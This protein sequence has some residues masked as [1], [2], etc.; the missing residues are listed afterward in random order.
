MGKT[1]TKQSWRPNTT[2]SGESV[3]FERA[4]A[5]ERW[6]LENLVAMWNARVPSGAPVTYWAIP[7]NPMNLVQTRTRS[8]AWVMGSTMVVM[9]DGV[10]G[11][12]ACDHLRPRPAPDLP[13]A[14]PTDGDPDAT[15]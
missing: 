3:R 1:R 11:A 13:G 12:V 6:R 8:A 4:N 7:D 14:P 10:T 2:P 15:P 5:L 9:L